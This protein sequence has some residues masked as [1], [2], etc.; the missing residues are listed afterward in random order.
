MNDKSDIQSLLRKYIAKTI[1]ADELREFRALLKDCTA[2]E[3][4]SLFQSEWDSMGDVESLDPALKMSMFAEIQRR[5]QPQHRVH[6]VRWS[7]GIAAS[8][9]ILLLSTLSY[10]LYSTGTCKVN[11]LSARN[12]E[13]KVAKG[14]RVTVTLPDG[15]VVRLNS[16][17]VL[18]YHQNFGL[19]DRN[20]NLNGEGFF[21]V[22]HNANQPFIV[23]THCLNVKVLGTR[24]NVYAY[25]KSDSI[26][27]DLVKGCVDVTTVNPPYQSMRVSPNQ[28]VIYSK[29][30]GQMRLIRTTNKFET[31]WL[32]NQ[33][34]FRSV[35][36]KEVLNLVGRKY[37]VTFNID[38]NISMNDL[39]TGVFDE[40]DINEVMDI[41]KI[42]YKFKYRI[43]DDTVWIFH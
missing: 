39:Y 5:I 4:K 9:L 22:T 17:S 14:E 43:K 7:I 24:F 3:M 28:K 21:D 26:E 10:Y 27:M 30:T 11:E 32:T 37:G 12:I 1:T 36:L 38:D 16:E 42:N 41:L 25:E 29:S 40:K 2:E 8:V 34:V 20:V 35:P 23:H 6:W 18:S 19:D 13:V 15:S 31:A 33:L